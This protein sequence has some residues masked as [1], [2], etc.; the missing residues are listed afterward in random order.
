ML[1]DKG[2]LQCERLLKSPQICKPCG[3]GKVTN[4]ARK[5]EQQERKEKM[6]LS[7]RLELGAVA[8]QNRPKSLINV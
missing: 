8:R 3:S 2:G 5:L 7:H 6:N 4:T 1:L